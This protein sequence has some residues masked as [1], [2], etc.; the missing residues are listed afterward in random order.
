MKKQ[1]RVP[2]KDWTKRW[3]GVSSW[4]GRFNPP[5][6]PSRGEIGIY[7]SYFR[8]VTDFKNKDRSM[9]VMGATALLRELG[10][11][12]GYRTTMIDVNPEMVKNQTAALR[13]Q[14][15]GEKF[16]QG[17]WRLMD[18]IF[19]RRKFD[20][21]VADH[22]I[23]NVPFRDWGKVYRNMRK[24]LKP[25]GHVFWAATVYDGR[26]YDTV[27]KA[28]KNFRMEKSD[29]ERFLRIYRFFGHPKYHDKA[30]GFHFGRLNRDFDSMAKNLLKPEQIRNF[31]MAVLDRWVCVVLKRN[32]FEEFTKKYFRVIRRRCDRSH[33][34]YKY[35]Q[36]YL[37]G[38]K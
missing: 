25:E 34:Y 21:I 28:I 30:H 5:W 11:K 10:H 23:I 15:P 3:K 32:K 8:Q 22:A 9:L 7:D 12:Y 29:T 33:V 38:Q 13:G 31:R 6:T 35:Q 27:T 26:K 19:Q 24:I 4:W 37:L 18:G 17:D 36:V 1:T 20:L 16:V 2:S 14:I